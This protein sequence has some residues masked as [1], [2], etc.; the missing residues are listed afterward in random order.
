MFNLKIKEEENPTSDGVLDCEVIK[1][2]EHE[3]I[4]YQNDRKQVVIITVL[5]MAL[6]WPRGKLPQLGLPNSIML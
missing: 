6:H 5:G 3:A 2:S 1:C 4:M